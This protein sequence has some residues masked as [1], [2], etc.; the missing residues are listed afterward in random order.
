MSV[1]DERA[2]AVAVFGLWQ[3]FQRRCCACAA[4]IPMIGG[5]VQRWLL[6]NPARAK[7]RPLPAGPSAISRIGWK[8]KLAGKRRQP[9]RA[10]ETS[11][12]FSTREVSWAVIPFDLCGLAFHDVHGGF[13]GDDAAQR[14]SG[15]REKRS[16]LG[17]RPLSP[18][19]HDH[20]HEVRYS[21]GLRCRRVLHAIRNHALDHS[22]VAFFAIARRQSGVSQPLRR[23][24]NR[25]SLDRARKHRR[26]QALQ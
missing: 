25:V 2:P 4:L 24:P 3:R 11:S 17:L 22:S 15:A 12:G 14:K 6:R 13:R 20:H 8:D 21:D 18:A 7:V 9:K 1:T 5:P 19:V 10:P 16:I 26:P 23:R